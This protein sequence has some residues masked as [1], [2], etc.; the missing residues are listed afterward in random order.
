MR[1]RPAK[2]IGIISIRAVQQKRKNGID[3]RKN[4]GHKE[5]RVVSRYRELA[6]YRSSY[7]CTMK[8]QVFN[9]KDIAIYN[10][11]DEIKSYYK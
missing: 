1:R 8:E 9:I 3:I 6:L 10:L 11:N 2:M 5:N 7:L 4:G